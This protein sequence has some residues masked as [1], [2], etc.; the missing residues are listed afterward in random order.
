M[1]DLLPDIFCLLSGSV[2]SLPRHESLERKPLFTELFRK[3]SFVLR[4]I[5]TC[6]KVMFLDIF[7]WLV[8]YVECYVFCFYIVFSLS[9]SNFISDLFL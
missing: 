6:I 8:F 5:G 7:I 2:I 1:L 4:L 9:F 3:F